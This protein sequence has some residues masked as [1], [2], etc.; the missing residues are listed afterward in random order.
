MAKH[1][2][3][4]QSR[5]LRR[6]LHSQK[7]QGTVGPPVDGA[8]DKFLP[9]PVSPVIRTV[10]SVGANLDTRREPRAGGG[11]PTISSNIDALS[12]SSAQRN[13]LVVKSA[14]QPVAILDIGRVRHTT[15]GRSVF[16]Q[17]GL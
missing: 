2:R 17:V 16:I 4:D 7:P 14:V 5:E 9:V 1:S 6:S 8:G 11:N 12:I 3:P 10:E 13:V 15:V